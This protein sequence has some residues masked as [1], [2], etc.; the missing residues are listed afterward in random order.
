MDK[1]SDKHTIY[2]GEAYSDIELETISDNVYISDTDD[3]ECVHFP[4]DRWEE[5]KAAIDK[6]VAKRLSNNTLPT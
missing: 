5:V 3:D 1:V 4:I 2:V 6:M